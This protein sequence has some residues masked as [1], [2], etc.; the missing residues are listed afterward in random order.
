MSV[1][2]NETKHNLQRVYPNGQ[3]SY[4]DVIKNVPLWM[5]QFPHQ[6]TKATFSHDDLPYIKDSIISL[7]GLGIKTVSANL[8]YEDVWVE[9]DEEIFENQLKELADYIIENSLWKDHSVRFFDPTIGFKLD[10]NTLESSVCGA[11]KMLA[12]DYA[13]NFYPCIRFLD[14]ALANNDGYLIGNVYSG[15]D[16]NKVTPFKFLNIKNQSTDECI[17]CDVASGCTSCTGLNYDN[18][19]T[20]FKRTTYNCKM[21]KANVRANNYF[22]NKLFI[23]TNGLIDRAQYYNSMKEKFM[24]IILE[25]SIEP[26]CSYQNN[27][28]N[29]R[30]MSQVMLEDALKFSENNGFQPVLLGDISR[31]DLDNGDYINIVSKS[32]NNEDTGKIIIYS[33]SNENLAISS[34]YIVSINI[35]NLSQLYTLVNNIVKLVIGARINIVIQ[36]IELWS[37]TDFINYEKQLDLIYNMLSEQSPLEEL[38]DINILTDKFEGL[39]DNQCTAGVDTFTL[40]PNGKVYTCPGFYFD[41]ESSEIGTINNFK[42]MSIINSYRCNSCKNKCLGCKFKNKKTTNEYSIPSDKQCRISE[43]QNRCSNKL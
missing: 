18:N 29:G 8:V 37:D 27:S 14:F 21:H 35:S 20:I 2:G 26:H 32:N 23:S 7:W 1:D 4:N 24:L 42:T 22:W 25:D 39:D 11:G 38:P 13:G 12:V 36:D 17:N 40:A 19:K 34:N 3:G 5:K 31:Y 6:V 33:N 10:N 9:G 28:K 15:I 41:N 16:S 30:L 43:I